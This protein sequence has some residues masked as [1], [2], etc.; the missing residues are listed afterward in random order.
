MFK[1]VRRNSCA[2]TQ[3]WKSVQQFVC[4]PADKLTVKRTDMGE[5]MT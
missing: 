1:T 3:I 2:E 4:N 5:N